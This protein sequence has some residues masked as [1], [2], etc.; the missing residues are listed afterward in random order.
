MFPLVSWI[1]IGGLVLIG[2][3]LVCLVPSKVKM[4]YART[5]VVG[6][7]EEKCDG[8]K[9]VCWLSGAGGGGAG[10]NG[11]RKAQRGC[12]PRGRAPGLPVRLQGFGGHLQHAGVPL[13]QARQGAHR[14]DAVAWAC[15]TSRSSQAFIR[16][17][18][19]AVYLAPPN[20]FG[21]IVPYASV[22]LGPGGD[23]AV[24]PQVPQAAS[25]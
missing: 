24:H 21:W 5:E 3:T 22:G 12:A 2:G 18:G 14:A 15:A 6:I 7:Y 20:A 23:L 19:A 11:S 9:V 4:Q 16:D 13:L 10:A 25:R 1:W 8:S 17:Y